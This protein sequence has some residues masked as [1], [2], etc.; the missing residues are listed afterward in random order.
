MCKRIFS[1]VLCL[2]LVVV[3]GLVSVSA[4]GNVITESGGS[5]SSV[6]VLTA[7]PVRLSYSTTTSLY[8]VDIKPFGLIMSDCLVNNQSVVPILIE[9]LTLID[10][11]ETEHIIYLNETLDKNSDINLKNVICSWF[12]N[13]NI[14]YSGVYSLIFK[15]TY[16]TH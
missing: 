16:A 14:E 9:S 7:E 13:N 2:V 4:T 10:D 1:C 5:A 12:E 3:L 11:K 8:C 15:I 6:V